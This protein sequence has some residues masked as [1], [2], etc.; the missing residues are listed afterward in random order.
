MRVTQSKRRFD[1]AIHHRR[2]IRVRGYDY[3][4]SGAY[5]VTLCVYQQESLLGEIADG[6]LRLSE[7]GSIVQDCWL[8]LAQSNSFV[9]H[10]TWVI[11][12]NHLHG[13]LMLSEPP[14]DSASGPKPLGRLIGAFKTTSTRRVN[15]LRD[16]LGAP[17]WQRDFYEHIVR[18]DL[19]LSRIR[20][21]IAANPRT[22]LQDEYNPANATVCRD[23][24]RPLGQ[25]PN[26]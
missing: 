16:A 21:Y 23:S 12:P 5:F 24:P 20:E 1:P 6:K 25:R 10:D 4:Q 26:S 11:M 18:N 7:I 3:R 13:I 2:S 19:D 9:Q 22:W 17:L 8:E 14:E 15:V